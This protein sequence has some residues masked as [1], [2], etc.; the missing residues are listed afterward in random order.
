MQGRRAICTLCQHLDEESGLSKC[1]AFPDGIPDKIILMDFLHVEPYE[2][3]GGIVFE[4]KPGVNLLD[5]GISQIID[6][7]VEENEE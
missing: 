7:E 4:P 1:T 6:E 5:E 3:D 2:G